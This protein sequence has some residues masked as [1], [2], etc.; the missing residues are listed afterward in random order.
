M[1]HPVMEAAWAETLPDHDGDAGFWK[2]GGEIWNGPYSRRIT[3]ITVQQD[4]PGLHCNLRRVCVWV[5]DVLAAEAPLH[6]LAAV[7]YPVPEDT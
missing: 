7:G 6:S 2:V 4:L 1:D 3:R 5:G